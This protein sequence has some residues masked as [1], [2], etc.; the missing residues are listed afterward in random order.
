MNRNRWTLACLTACSILTAPAQ[1]IPPR[2]VIPATIPRSEVSTATMER[3]HQEV[4]TPFKYGIVLK[5]PNG[6]MVDNPGVFRHG[7]KWYM[8]YV[9]FNGSGYQT[10]LATS[11][12]L[13]DWQPLGTILPFRDHS[14][15]A[16]QAAGYIALQDTSWGGSYQLATHNQKYWMSYLGGNLK[17]YESDPL[18]IGL[19]WTTN[20]TNPQPWHRLDAPVLTRDQPD[21][22]PWEKLTQYKSNIIHDKE[23]SLGH[24]FVMF[25]NAKTNSGYERI[26]MAVSS[27]MTTWHRYGKDPVIDNG[28][29]IS[30][31]PQITRIGDVWVMF[32]FGAFWKPKAFDTFACSHDLVHWTRWTGPHLVEPSEP[33]DQEYAHKPWVVKHDGIV[34]HFYNAVGNQGRVIALATSKDLRKPSP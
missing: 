24:P 33:W 18:M 28:S 26:G 2:E 11:Q 34:Y 29:G 30:G 4:R 14:W 21:C 17:G 1:S 20:P 8:T 6:G 23:R 15:D 22:R 3:I 9:I 19:A 5:D 12:N 25:Y 31:D 27:D 16:A 7:E 10:A 32:Y 13:L